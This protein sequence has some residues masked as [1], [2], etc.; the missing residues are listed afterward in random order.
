[1]TQDIKSLISSFRGEEEEE[2]VK[3]IIVKKADEHVLLCF[4]KINT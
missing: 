4:I 1:M 3:E 2:N